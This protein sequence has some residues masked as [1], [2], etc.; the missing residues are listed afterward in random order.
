MPTRPQSPNP[1][2]ALAALGGQNG[3]T[4]GA[5]NIGQYV[6][7]AMLAAGTIGCTCETCR[8][9]GK[10]AVIMRKNLLEGDDDGGG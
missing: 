2:A 8:L 9:M 6:T 7:A 4:G 1:M 10:A 3:P 5:Q